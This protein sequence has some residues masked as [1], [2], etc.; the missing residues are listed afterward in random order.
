M[1]AVDQIEKAEGYKEEGNRLYAAGSHQQALV[2][3]HKVFCYLDGLQPAPESCGR[4]GAAGQNFNTSYIPRDRIAAVKQLKQTT[5]LN[6]AA[7]YLKIGKHQKC[8]EACN[9]AL[10][11][12]ETVKA[13]FRRGQAYAELRNFAGAISDLERARVLAP[14]DAAVVSELRKVK[15][16]FSGGGNQKERQHAAKML[17]GAF[18]DSKESESISI[19]NTHLVTET[20]LPVAPQA[21]S[22]AAE[23]IMP[24]VGVEH[25]TTATDLVVANAS[26]VPMVSAATASPPDMPSNAATL[27][28]RVVAPVTTL[29][30]DEARR[31]EVALRQLSYAWQQSD[32]DIKIYISF[33]QAD[34]LHAGVDESRVEVEYGEWSVLLIIRPAPSPSC[35]ELGVCGEVASDG[36]HV[37]PLGLRLGDFYRRLEPGMCRCTVRSSR[38]TLKLVKKVKEH[39]WSLLQSVP[40]NAG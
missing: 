28:G 39:W 40:L 31:P 36:R 15:I 17:A 13:Y 34:E 30:L 20:E 26:A 29:P 10:E 6:M 23:V 16:A 7:C 25:T 33:D 22:C 32:E 5:R 19:D 18:Q 8:V 9:K 3:Y 12:G 11:F 24:S 21:A 2:P 1:S 27:A 38:I 14:K 35:D 4:D 37:P